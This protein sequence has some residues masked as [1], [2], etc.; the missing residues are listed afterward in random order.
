[1]EIRLQKK[2]DDFDINIQFK[3]ESKHVGIL[4]ESGAGKSVALK[5]IS[6]I[7][8][9]NSGFIRF[10]NSVILDSEKSINL[11]PQDRKIGYM[12]QNYALFPNMTVIQNV[13]AGIKEVN[14]K[15]IA[16]NYLKNFKIDY[17]KDKYPNQLSGGQQQRVAMARMLAAKPNVLLFDEPFSALDSHL[18]DRVRIELLKDLSTFK[19][20]TVMVTHDRDEAYQFC[21]YLVLLSEGKVVEAG[22]TKEIFESPKTKAGAILTGVKN[23]SKIEK[24]ND[25]TIKALDWGNIILKTDDLVSN[26]H[27]YVGIRAHD[28]IDASDRNIENVIPV[29]NASVTEKPFE[30]QIV[31]END[32]Y[33]K[34]HKNMHEHTFKEIIPNMIALPSDRLM[35]Y[36]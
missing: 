3:T 33:I 22:S 10:D 32:I 18:K 31:L 1:M 26:N 8:S 2:L 21:D 16:L 7:I 24:I 20:H 17:L 23:I 30:W 15:A 6:G 19:G 5:M 34:K 14:K 4:G 35:L 27:N 36:Y 13:M 28:I 29:I 12:F 9:A 11:K 25:Y